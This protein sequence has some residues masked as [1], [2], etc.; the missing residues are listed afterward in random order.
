MTTND[1]ITIDQR[2]LSSGKAARILGVS[3]PVL[4]DL[5]K[6]GDIPCAETKGGHFRFS[7]QEIVDY[8]LESGLLKNKN[9]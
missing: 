5:A 6:A 8:G 2:N 7:R 4:L 9:I 1:E 3:I